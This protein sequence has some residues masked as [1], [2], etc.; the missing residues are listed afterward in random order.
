M[1]VK[2]SWRKCRRYSYYDIAGCPLWHTLKELGVPVEGVGGSHVRIE[3]VPSLLPL[4]AETFNI[5][6]V[7]WAA[8]RH[9][10]IEAEITGL[11]KYIGTGTKG[12]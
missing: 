8:R 10:S 5:K 1:K 9:R 3:N 2:V 12:K 11:E 6:T 7:E 4:D